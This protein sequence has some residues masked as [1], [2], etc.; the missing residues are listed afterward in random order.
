MQ[1]SASGSNLR[2]RV[3]QTLRASVGRVFSCFDGGDTLAVKQERRSVHVTYISRRASP[4]LHDL[5]FVRFRIC[6]DANEIWIGNLNVAVPLRSLGLGR[7]LVQVVEETARRAGIPNIRLFPLMPSVAFWEKMGYSPDARAARTLAKVL[8]TVSA[9]GSAL[10]L[11][12]QLVIDSK[13]AGHSRG[14]SERTSR[15][16]GAECSRLLAAPIVLTRAE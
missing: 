7:Q 16:W 13:H 10:Q 12:Q 8:Q 5:T 1:Q 3:E 6:V 9:D 15:K 11:P 4:D 14:C 2:S